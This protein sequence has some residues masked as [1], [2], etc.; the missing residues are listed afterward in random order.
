MISTRSTILDLARQRGILR[1][2]ELDELGLSRTALSRLV[3]S[4]AI[5][6]LSRGLYTLPNREISEHATLAEVAMKYPGAIFCLLSALQLHGVSTQTPHQVWIAIDNKARAPKMD[7]PPLKVIRFSGDAL[8]SGVQDMV[9][10]GVVHIPVTN[11]EKTI[12]D[13]FK[14][15]NKIGLDVAIEALQEAWRTKRVTMDGLWNFA[16]ICR[17]SNV[18]RPYLE[19]LI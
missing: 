10:D 16:R 6:R 8:E 12:A 15:R 19:S 13:C 14:F 4:G 2:R 11:L 1:S 18:M 17:V 7:Y 3:E 9:V 5:L